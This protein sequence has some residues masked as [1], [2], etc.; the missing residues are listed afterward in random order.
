MIE[1][2]AMVQ[3]NGIIRGELNAVKISNENLCK[4]I[5]KIKT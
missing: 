5:L 1:I 2:M 3:H 4:N